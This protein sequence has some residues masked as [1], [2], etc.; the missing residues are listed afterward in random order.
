MTGADYDPE[1]LRA[2][3]FATWVFL[4]HASG[5]ESVET[6]VRDHCIA[7]VEATDE[8]T[9]E[10][11]VM[12]LIDNVSGGLGDGVE[13]LAGALYGDRVSSEMGEGNRAER[14]RRIRMYE[15]K[16]WLPW[17]AKIYQRSDQGDV[18]AVWVVVERLSNE[19]SIMDPNPWND[20]DEEYDLPVSDFHVLWELA[21]KASVHLA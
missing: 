16:N 8:E 3:T 1:T 4:L 2:Y 19:V 11:A 7:I 15:F 20:I 10:A 14:S 17:L 6:T 21:A 9:G 13:A 5:V 18:S 12:A